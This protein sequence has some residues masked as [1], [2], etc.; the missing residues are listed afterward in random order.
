MD[1]LWP[2][3]TNCAVALTFDVDGEEVYLADDPANANKPGLLSQ[4]AYGPKVGVPLILGMLARHGI[5]AT[6]FAPG[7]SAERHPDA[8]RAIVEGGHELAH[9]GYTHTSPTLLSFEQEEDELVHGLDVLRSF[10][11]DVVGYRSPAWEFTENSLGLLEKHGFR[12]SSNFMDDVKPYR[13]PN[14]LIELPVQWILDDAAHFW[15][16]GDTWNKTIRSAA[17]VRQIY[18][19]EFEGIR[20]LGGLFVLTMHPEISGRPGRL[21]M[22]DDFVGSLLNRGDVWLATCREIADR[23]P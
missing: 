16:E 21:A 3:G 11:A 13:H 7:R 19:E 12:Y 6:F 9:H 23:V 17:E 14:G 4:G 1:A 20:R 8:I 22:L 2:E 5:R 10:G 15:F 18:D